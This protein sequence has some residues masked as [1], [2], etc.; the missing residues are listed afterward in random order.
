MGK[1]SPGQLRQGSLGQ[2]RAVVLNS[3]TKPI[4]PVACSLPML[5][6]F[7]PSKFSHPPKNLSPQDS[8]SLRCTPR[9]LSIMQ[10][11][12]FS[13]ASVPISHCWGNPSSRRKPHTRP[14]R[15]DS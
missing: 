2:A 14:H 1:G 4:G 7:V 13:L 8:G 11:N 10:V 5:G 12:L 3:V 15:T 9:A 6:K